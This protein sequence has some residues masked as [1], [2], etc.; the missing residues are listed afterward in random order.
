VCRKRYWNSLTIHTALVPVSFV[1]ATHYKM[2]YFQTR[3]FK[4]DKELFQKE[5][6]E[7]EESQKE[8]LT[9]TL[10]C[11]PETSQKCMSWSKWHSRIHAQK[12]LKPPL[13]FSLP[14]ISIPFFGKSPL[15][16]SWNRTHS[17]LSVYYCSISATNILRKFYQEV[18]NERLL[19]SSNL[20]PFQ[21]GFHK[22]CNSFQ[23]FR[24]QTDE[25]V[26]F[27]DCLCSVFFENFLSVLKTSHLS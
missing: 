3:Q 1:F 23:V 20:S 18:L 24:I 11:Y 9:R 15:H 7:K 8:H 6:I 5:D 13:S 22:G 26:Y 2:Y 10:H 14:K 12:S 19:E 27:N 16:L 4:Y 25:A 21:Y 17:Y